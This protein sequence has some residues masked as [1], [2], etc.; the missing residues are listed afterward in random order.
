MGNNHGVRHNINHNPD[1]FSNFCFATRNLNHFNV[2][3]TP[4][5]FPT[6]NT[7]NGNSLTLVYK[8][9]S[10]MLPMI[11]SVAENSFHIIWNFTRQNQ[12]A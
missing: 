2:T 4:M 1:K 10:A 6:L 7:A 3:D 12:Q 8:F 9:V 11:N 5:N